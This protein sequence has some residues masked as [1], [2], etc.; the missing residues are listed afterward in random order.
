MASLEEVEEQRKIL[1]SHRRTLQHY[2]NQQA[3]LGSGF[4]PPAVTHGIAES[5]MQIQ[6]LKTL[7]RSWNI[8]EPT[9]PDDEEPEIISTGLGTPQMGEIFLGESIT[10]TKGI[11]LDIIAEEIV[12]NLE[13]SVSPPF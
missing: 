7:L 8:E 1:Q 5:R 13:N 12:F 6:R 2:L 10:L 11:R 9:H 4:S 3:L